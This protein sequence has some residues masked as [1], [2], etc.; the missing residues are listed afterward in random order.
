MSWLNPYVILGVVLAII[1]AAGGGYLKGH[2]D[3]D[4][5]AEILQLKADKAALQAQAQEAR[6]QAEASA[7][8]AR[9]AADRQKEIEADA[10]DMQAEI[11]DYAKLVESQKDCTCAFSADDVERLRRIGSSPRRAA[12]GPA[13]GPLIL[14]PAPGGVSPGR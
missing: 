6:R 11:E 4:R 9:A 12:P 5:S 13:G 14:H 1:A 7:A 10:A 3:A 8:I 2:R